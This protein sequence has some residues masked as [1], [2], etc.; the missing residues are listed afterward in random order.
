MEN[1]V[2]NLKRAL[3]YA[4]E[5]GFN[6]SDFYS[7]NIWEEE[8][9]LQTVHS[10]KCNLVHFEIGDDGFYRH[11]GDFFGLKVRIIMEN[12]SYA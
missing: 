6:E 3:K 4:K 7:I 11:N 5:M 1:S 10:K 12:E 9:R 2:R 8:V